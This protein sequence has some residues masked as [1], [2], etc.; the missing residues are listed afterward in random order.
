[1]GGS[2]EGIDMD[3]DAVY[4]E[5]IDMARVAVAAMDGYTTDATVR[6][7]LLTFFG[8]QEDPSTHTVS[9]GSAA[10]FSTVRANL[11]EVINDSQR[12]FSGLFPSLFCSEKWRWSTRY[13]HSK[14][15]GKPTGKL[16][17]SINPNTEWL[18]W[19]PRFKEYGPDFDMCQ[20]DVLAF[21]T[22]QAAKLSITLCPRIFKY[23]RRKVIVL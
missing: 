4:R 13:E 2:C 14:I 18:T 17:K 15:T 9:A 12:Q 1:M 11:Q 16:L 5:A 19:S 23:P 7:S 8:I 22:S 21:T 6:A 3:L 20:G 10:R